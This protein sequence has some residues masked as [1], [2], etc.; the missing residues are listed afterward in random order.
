MPTPAKPVFLEHS[1]RIMV[2]SHKTVRAR[3]HPYRGVFTSEFRGVGTTK[4]VPE[5]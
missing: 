5:D 1:L 2:V 4:I 3:P